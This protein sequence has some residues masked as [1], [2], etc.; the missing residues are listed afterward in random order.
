MIETSKRYSNGP[1]HRIFIKGYGFFPL[2]W[3]MLLLI[4]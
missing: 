4:M 2:L 1:K 3:F